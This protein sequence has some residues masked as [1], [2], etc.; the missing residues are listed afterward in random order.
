MTNL[1]T[2]TSF[3]FTREDRLTNAIVVTLEHA[4]TKLLEAFLRLVTDDDPAP[5]VLAEAAYELQPDFSDSRPDAR[6]TTPVHTVVI[7]TKRGEA[8]D[9]EQFRRHFEHI[10][11]TPDECTTTLLSLTRARRAPDV[12]REL[13]DEVNHPELSIRHLPWSTLVRFFDEQRKAYADCPVTA[14]LLDHL[15]DFLKNNGYDYFNGLDMDDLIDYGETLK[16]LATHQ[17]TTRQRLRRLTNAL[18]AEVRDA[19][20]SVDLEWR[21]GSFRGLRT[22]RAR[23]E[24]MESY[25]PAF[26]EQ[27]SPKFRFFPSVEKD[28]RLRFLYYFTYSDIEDRWAPIIDWI[29][30]HEKEIGASIGPLHRCTVLPGTDVFHIAKTLPGD[31]LLALLEGDQETLQNTAKEL[32]AFYSRLHDFLERAVNEIG[33]R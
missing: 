24:Y 27:R 18:A 8:L 1:F 23:F 5:E 16:S 15:T 28:G 26:G 10:R 25:V 22:H 20:D 17:K 7:E 9:D 31:Q 32:A 13:A 29:R 14:F 4:D 3:R 19:A 12:V 11:A 2:D 30:E 6:I 21:R 33:Q